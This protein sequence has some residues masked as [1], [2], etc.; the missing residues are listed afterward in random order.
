MT[1]RIARSA[2]MRRL[3]LEMADEA[4]RLAKTA[5][6]AADAYSWAEPAGWNRSVG[7]MERSKPGHSTPTE[8]VAV[9]K[10]GMRVQIRVAHASIIK[11]TNKLAE[12]RDR[13]EAA[14]DSRDQH[15]DAG[16]RTTPFPKIVS[17]AELDQAQQAQARRTA[18]GEG[19]G[20]G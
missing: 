8:D 12:A 18:R 16:T 14:L 19:W 1:R 3:L 6:E 15:R 10:S 9:G 7:E 11:A 17:A 5:R 4:E 2:P 20:E 13:L